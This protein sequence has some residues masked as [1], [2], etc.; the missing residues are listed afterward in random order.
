MV[1]EH[2]LVTIRARAARWIP[3][4]IRR[5]QIHILVQ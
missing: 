5:V 1:V 3:R 2:R 4:V